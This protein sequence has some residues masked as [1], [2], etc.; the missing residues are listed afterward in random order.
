MVEVDYM[1]DRC[2]ICLEESCKNKEN[3]VKPYSCNC[4]GCSIKEKCNK[5][6]RPTI[7][8]T[9][10]CTQLC[11]HCC[12]ECSPNR[13]DMMTIDIANDISIFLKNNNIINAQIM[14]GEFFCN[15]DYERIIS[16]LC[17]NL[18]R[19]RLVTNGDWAKN[20]SKVI[21]MLK[22]N[23]KIYVGISVDDYHTNKYVNKAKQLSNMTLISK[24]LNVC[25]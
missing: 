9:T 18:K 19:V 13:T 12:F 24:R 17:K 21:A 5:I 8:M 20:P 3:D 1:N 25:F 11:S 15:P 2:N 22:N 16:I 6:L 7:R 23:D 14:G 4:E 10:K